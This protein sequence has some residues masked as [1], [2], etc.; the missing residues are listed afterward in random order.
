MFLFKV[1]ETFLI[2][3]KGLILTPGF[4]DETILIGTKIK[5]VRP[6]NSSIKT[7]V[8]GI[9]FGPLRHMLIEKSIKKSDVPIGTEVWLSN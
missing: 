9:T 8:Q 6:D 3:G 7:T 1:E 5:L 2:T 4:S